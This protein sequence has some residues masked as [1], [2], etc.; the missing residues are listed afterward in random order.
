MT[1]IL[2]SVPLFTAKSLLVAGS[3]AV[4]S[5]APTPPKL[6]DAISRYPDKSSFCVSSKGCATSF[7]LHEPKTSVIAN[8]LSRT[9]FF[10]VNLNLS[11][12]LCLLC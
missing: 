6:M 3:K 5:A 2:F 10:I 1:S 12:K 9:Y 4:I 11:M 7:L 8:K